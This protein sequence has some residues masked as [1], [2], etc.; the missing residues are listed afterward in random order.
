[1]EEGELLCDWTQLTDNHLQELVASPELQSITAAMVL[2][3]VTEI[4]TTVLIEIQEH[5][6]IYALQ[7]RKNA[8]KDGKNPLLF[9]L[10]AGWTV[11]TVQKVKIDPLPMN[12]VEASTKPG[13]IIYVMTQNV[14]AGQ[15]FFTQVMKY[16]KLFM[17]KMDGENI[18][19]QR[20]RREF[21][22]RKTI[23]QALLETMKI[24]TVKHRPRIGSISAVHQFLETREDVHKSRD[25]HRRRVHESIFRPWMVYKRREQSN[26]KRFIEE[27]A[28][29]EEKRWV[30]MK[31]LFHEVN[32]RL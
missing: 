28:Q 2:K 1:M 31:N 9:P 20:L 26:S 24:D 22:L 21:I 19:V 3:S 14:V 29:I 30:R 18:L 5:L 12:I 27:L 7:V 6:V 32:D 15:S 16:T 13:R 23:W 11:H 8:V 4:L 25:Y 10:T 17:K